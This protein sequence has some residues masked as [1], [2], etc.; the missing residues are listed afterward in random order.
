MDGSAFCIRTLDQR[1]PFEAAGLLALNNAHAGEL[2]RLSPEGMARL[3]G[4]A[5]LACGIGESQGLLVALDERADYLSPNFL[6][7]RERFDRFVYVDR[8]VIA[9]HARGRGLAQALYRALFLSARA[10][11][12]ERIVCEVNAD[13]PN[14]ASDRFH[15]AMG[16]TAIGAAALSNGKTVR[17]YLRPLTELEPASAV[18]S[19]LPTPRDPR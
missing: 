15:A 5:F 10:A 4:Q 19:R 11:G 2:S 9:T 16:F 6:W 1:A 8:I 17:Y 7:F 13:P 12:H 3:I 14:P 18:E